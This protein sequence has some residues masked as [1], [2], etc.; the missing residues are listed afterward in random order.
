MK[1]SNDDLVWIVKTDRFRNF[2]YNRMRATDVYTQEDLFGFA[3]YTRRTNADLEECLI[4][5]LKSSEVETDTDRAE[6]N[7][8]MTIPIEACLVHDLPVRH[9]YD[10]SRQGE[11][12]VFAR[13]QATIIAHCLGYKDRIISEKWGVY[14]ITVYKRRESGIDIAETDSEYTAKLYELACKF[15]LQNHELL[16]EIFVKFISFE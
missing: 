10:S 6:T 15:N 4:Q 13:Q 1:N 5:Y 7:L 8:L 9:F 14:R 2:K 16:S 11:K 3:R 12:R